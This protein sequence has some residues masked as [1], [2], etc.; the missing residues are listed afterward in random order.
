MVKKLILKGLAIVFAILILL[1]VICFFKG[2]LEM[3]PAPEQEGKARI[4]AA[5]M[6]VFCA[7]AE[8]ILITAIRKEG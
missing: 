2:S 3:F 8:G 7:I 1:A 5:L 6:A 4:A